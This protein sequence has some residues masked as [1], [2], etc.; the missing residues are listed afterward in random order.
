MSMDG[1]KLPIV[2]QPRHEILGRQIYPGPW[3][4]YATAPPSITWTLIPDWS[5][6]DGVLGDTQVEDGCREELENN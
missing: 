5:I 6:R 3:P 4:H 1:R 2:G